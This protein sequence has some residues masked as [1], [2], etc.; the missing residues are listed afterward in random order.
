LLPLTWDAAEKPKKDGELWGINYTLGGARSL[1]EKV[2]ISEAKLADNMQ[3]TPPNCS[4]S[5]ISNC[6]PAQ[7]NTSMPQAVEP[8]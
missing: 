4:L 8:I 3:N 7:I 5:Q 2:L 6:Y 1:R